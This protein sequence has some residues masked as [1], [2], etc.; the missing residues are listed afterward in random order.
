MTSSMQWPMEFSPYRRG[1]VRTVEL[2]FRVAMVQMRSAPL[3]PLANAV[4]T[5]AAITR[6]AQEGSTL[7]VLPEL[8]AT[9]YIPDRGALEPLAESVADP[10]PVLSAWVEAARTQQVAVIGGFAEREGDNLYN[11]AVT[12][13]ATGRIIS[14]YRKRHLFGRERECFEPGDLGLPIANVSGVEVG[15]LVCYDLRFPEAMRIMALRGAE[16]IAVPTAW[17]SGFDKRVPAT[18]R[19][20]Q[21]DGVVVQANLNQVFVVCADTVG[22]VSDL[23]FLGRSVAVNPFGEIIAGPLSPDQEECTIVD[24]DVAEVSAARHRG[25]GID[26]FA[27]RRTDVYGAELG[28]QYV[29]PREKKEKS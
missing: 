4:T 27:N 29:S 9:G 25:L 13:D 8:A 17:V 18:G 11:S 14:I 5:S 15:V 23:A 20:G 1:D 12:I 19:I 16:V 7:V 3:E 26:P 24:I 28:Y 2:P 21:I 6:C 10:G 22:V